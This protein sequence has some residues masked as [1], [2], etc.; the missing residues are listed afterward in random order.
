MG[1][2]GELRKAVHILLSNKNYLSA[3]FSADDE[4]RTP[5]PIGYILIAP[6][7]SEDHEYDLLTPEKFRET[8]AYTGLKLE[9][10]FVEVRRREL[11]TGNDGDPEDSG[12]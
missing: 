2:P 5:M 12:D 7:N 3:R 10:G 9:N 1:N 4:A 6:F 11:V 8:F